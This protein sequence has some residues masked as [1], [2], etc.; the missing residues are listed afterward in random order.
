[1]SHRELLQTQGESSLLPC[2]QAP[3]KLTPRQQAHAARKLKFEQLMQTGEQEMACLKQ[4]DRSLLHLER[5]SK[6][7]RHPA[8][9]QSLQ[10]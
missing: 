7:F 8:A 3:P 6:K 1:M 5:I 9:R 2:I 4:I 10:V